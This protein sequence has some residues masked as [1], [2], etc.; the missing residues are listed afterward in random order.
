VIKE[1]FLAQLRDLY[2]R[3]NFKNLQSFLKSNLF[4]KGEM[5]L[6]ETTLNQA[7]NEVKHGLG[8]KPTD[9]LITSATG[10]VSISHGA[11]TPESITLTVT[12][13]PVTVRV[14]VGK[15]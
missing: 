14:L 7:N 13:P 12:T 2:I 1:F 15:L 5:K 11:S 4:T 3:E 10:A 9:I 8:F 6:L